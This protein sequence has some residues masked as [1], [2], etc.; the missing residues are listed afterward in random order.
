MLKIWEGYGKN[1][2]TSCTKWTISFE[3]SGLRTKTH[4]LQRDFSFLELIWTL[5]FLCVQ[6]EPFK[7]TSSSFNPF[8]H[9][10]LFFMHLLICFELNDSEIEKHYKWT[11]KRLKLGMISSFHPHR[12]RKK[13]G[14]LRQKLDALHV[15]NWTIFFKVSGFRTKTHVLHWLIIIL[16]T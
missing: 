2:C 12:M 11:L 6:N 5:G 3:V 9:H 4:L 7:A 15:Q 13:L 1:W 10:L 8:W 16:I 14:G